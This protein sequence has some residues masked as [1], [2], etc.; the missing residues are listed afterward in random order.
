[1]KKLMLSVILSLVLLMGLAVAE[2]V[3][4]GGQVEQIA[5][6][7]EGQELPA[8]LDALFKDQKVVLH[9]QD[10]GKEEFMISLAMN[11]KVVESLQVGDLENPTLEVFTDQATLEQVASASNP[12]QEL[13]IAFDNE[14]ISYQAYGFFNKMKFAMVFRMWNT[15]GAYG[16]DL[17]KTKEKTKEKEETKTESEKNS[18]TETETEPEVESE[19]ETEVEKE[20]ETEAES[21]ETE[22][23]SET[24]TE[25]TTETEISGPQ[26]HTVL[27]D[28][29]GFAVDEL[30]I[31]VGDTVVFENTRSGKFKQAMVIGS[32]F[33]CNKLVSPVFNKGETYSWT[34]NEAGECVIVDG[35]LVT[36][37]MTINVQE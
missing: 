26:T 1:M 6:E 5:A 33:I 15:F 25:D 7:V 18:E 32:R 27:M 22:T 16:D 29:T 21:E 3:S 9:L 31:K 23:E 11:G 36:Q 24:E 4:L 12:V 30:D 10:P 8:P 13:K 28:D 14:K 20:S 34:F 2:V 19:T 17:D 35:I 37:I